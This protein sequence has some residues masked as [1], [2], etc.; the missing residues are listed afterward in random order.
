M[1]TLDP[2]QFGDLIAGQSE[3]VTVSYRISDG[4]NAG[5]RNTATITVEGRDETV[6]G[7]TI[8]GTSA[9]NTLTGGEGNGH[10][11]RPRAATTRC[12]ASAATTRSTAAPAPTISTAAPATT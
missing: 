9:S 12:A 2:A 4:V 7:Q 1:L 8:T 11:Q 3:V 5:V 6:P 10:D